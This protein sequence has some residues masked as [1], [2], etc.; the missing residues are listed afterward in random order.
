[1]FQPEDLVADI[2]K[3]I[4]AK[5]KFE[6]RV[7]TKQKRIEAALNLETNKLNASDRKIKFL[8]EVN[9]KRD[10]L[11]AAICRAKFEERFARKHQNRLNNEKIKQEVEIQEK[12]AAILLAIHEIETKARIFPRE[13]SRGKFRSKSEVDIRSRGHIQHRR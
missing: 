1:M 9:A 7:K 11:E 10:Q 3:A 2:Q 12:R 4:I 5:K 6:K 13:K 8:N